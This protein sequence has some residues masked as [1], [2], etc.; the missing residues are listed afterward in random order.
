[1]DVFE[2]RCKQFW[3]ELTCSY[4]LRPKTQ[5]CILRHPTGFYRSH[6]MYE[7]S[8]SYLYPTGK[9]LSEYR[10]LFV[11]CTPVDIKMKPSLASISPKFCGCSR[12][13]TIKNRWLRLWISIQLE[14][15]LYSGCHGK[16]LLFLEIVNDKKKK[17]KKKCIVVS[18]IW[19]Q[20]CW[21]CIY[22]FRR[23]KGTLLDFFPSWPCIWI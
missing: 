4:K 18:P 17:K 22:I 7:A 8:T 9:R 13:M 11:S 21:N 15:P 3:K 20:I 6:H 10:P 16:I 2:T 23:R 19:D 14:C 1:M 5:F 12:M